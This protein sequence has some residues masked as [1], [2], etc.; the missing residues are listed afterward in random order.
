MKPIVS[1][2][3]VLAFCLILALPAVADAAEQLSG[4]YVLSEQQR[5]IDPTDFFIF[6]NGSFT[7]GSRHGG[8]TQGTY[9]ITDDRIELVTSDGKIYTFQFS[10][11]SNAIIFGE[12]SAATIFM[13][14]T[15]ERIAAIEAHRAKGAREEARRTEE[16]RIAEEVVR[17]VEKAHKIEFIA[18][19]ESRMN[20]SDAK[21]FCQR[22]G[23]RLPRINNSDSWAGKGKAAIDGF[24]VSGASWPSDLP[25]ANYWM[26]TDYAG[27]PGYSWLV[28]VNDGNVH[29]FNRRQSYDARVVCV[30]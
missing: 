15:N 22:R 14:L 8:I 11:T 23:G 16:T 1:R 20:W 28:Y 17:K 5:S 10:R 21:A 9:S 7:A 6:S 12:G 3:L 26:G 25:E 30:P 18:Q 13:R 27:F 2:S 29:I 4:T 24:G 19:S